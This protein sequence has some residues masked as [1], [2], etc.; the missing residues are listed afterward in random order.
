MPASRLSPARATC[1]PSA[2]PASVPARAPSVNADRRFP[3]WRRCATLSGRKGAGMVDPVTVSVVGLR[4]EAIVQE[5]GEVLLR[6]SY[7]QILNSSRDF[8][9]AVTD[10]GGRLVAQAEHIPIHVGAIPYAVE[11]LRGF[12]GDR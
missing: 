9:T 8:S 3:R 1:N 10:P 2:N 11:S 12:F 5:M 7:S 4:L 6:T